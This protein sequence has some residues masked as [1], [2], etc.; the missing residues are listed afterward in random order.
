MATDLD[1]SPLQSIIRESDEIILVTHVRPDGDAV[2]SCLGLALLIRSMGK[3]VRI[4]LDGGCPPGLLF[5]KPQDLIAPLGAHQVPG[6][7]GIV[8]V[9]T[10]TWNQVGEASHLLKTPGRRVVVVDHHRTQDDLGA[11]R[12]VD[13]ESESASALVERFYRKMGQTPDANGATALFAGLAYDTGWFRHTNCRQSTFEL[14]ARLA[15]WGAN[16]PWIH[17]KMFSGESLARQ[18]VKGHVLT[19]MSLHADGQI[20]MFKLLQKDLAGIGVADDESLGGLVD[21]PRQVAGVRVALALYE[22]PDGATRAS[23][24]SD[25]TVDVAAI[26]A[27]HGGGGHKPA[28]GC[29]IVG[30]PDFAA[31]VLVPEL[32]AS[33]DAGHG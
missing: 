1:W 21:L 33:L 15:G 22:Q 32:M 8:V 31:S 26:C 19:T 30:G 3:K 13:V 24:R 28:A 6:H 16:A 25:G 7:A 9:D 11:P 12:I 27:R 14:A 29:S 10:G 18:R 5:L 20:G 2:G 4:D 17:E 23:L